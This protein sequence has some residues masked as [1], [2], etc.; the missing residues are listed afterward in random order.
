MYRAEK[1]YRLG[2]EIHR[3]ET[4]VRAF[5]YINQQNGSFAA[6]IVKFIIEREYFKVVR[7]RVGNVAEFKAIFFA[8]F[9]QVVTHFRAAVEIRFTARRRT[10]IGQFV[11]SAVIRRV[12]VVSAVLAARVEPVRTVYYKSLTDR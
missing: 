3:V 4:S 2:I 8:F 1:R 6:H 5:G 11:Y 7:S 12:A 9:K 10:E